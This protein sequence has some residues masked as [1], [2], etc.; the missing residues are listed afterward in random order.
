M[1]EFG[2]TEADNEEERWHAFE[3]DWRVASWLYGCLA[4]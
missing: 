4:M 1:E 2:D 3:P